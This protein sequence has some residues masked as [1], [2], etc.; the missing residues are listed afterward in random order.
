M[1]ALDTNTVIHFFKRKGNTDP[2]RKFGN[3]PQA[4]G[5]LRE[6]T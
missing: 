5:L 3:S 1:F 6:W 2:K 4:P